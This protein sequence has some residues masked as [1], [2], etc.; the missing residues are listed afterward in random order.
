M[1]KACASDVCVLGLRLRSELGKGLKL[2]L[3]ARVKVWPI[4]SVTLLH[5]HVR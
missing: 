4:G 3:P 1:A 2:T 5:L